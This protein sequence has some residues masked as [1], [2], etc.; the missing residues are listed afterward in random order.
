VLVGQSRRANAGLWYND[1]AEMSA[2]IPLLR[3]Q[4]GEIMGANGRDFVQ[5]SYAWPKVVEKY[6]S[7]YDGT[8]VPAKAS[9]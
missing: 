5:R 1:A 8:A 2:A 7:V 4:P 9:A 6:Q 3:E